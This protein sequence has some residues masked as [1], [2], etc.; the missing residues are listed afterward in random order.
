VVPG[1]RASAARRYLEVGLFVLH[2][3]SVAAQEALLARVARAIEPGG[4]LLIRDADAAGGWRFLAVRIQERFATIARRQPR[5]R[6]HYRS[7][8]ELLDL[9]ASLGFA[10]EVEPMGMGTPYANVLIRARRAACEQG[11]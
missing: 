7:A 4:V 8:R 3:M 1:D 10:A 11:H 5:Q 6:F 2:Y 9:L